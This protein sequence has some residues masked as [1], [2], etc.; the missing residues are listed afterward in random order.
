[1]NVFFLK[2]FS[3]GPGFWL[4]FVAILLDFVAGVHYFWIKKL[5]ESK[6]PQVR[7]IQ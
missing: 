3:V 1:M 6:Q 2:D 5:T 7:Y 4:C